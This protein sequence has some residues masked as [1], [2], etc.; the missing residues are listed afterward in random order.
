MINEDSVIMNISD[1]AGIY[2]VPSV[3][4]VGQDDYD[5]VRI[6]CYSHATL[7]ILCFAIDK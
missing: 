7:F 3:P 2:F 5:R 4:Y 1:T 6:L